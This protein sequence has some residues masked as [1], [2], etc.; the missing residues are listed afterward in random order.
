MF[1]MKRKGKKNPQNSC[2]SRRDQTARVSSNFQRCDLAAFLRASK[3]L[4]SDVGKH[5]LR[6]SEPLDNQRSFLTRASPQ[7]CPHSA[8]II[9]DY[10]TASNFWCHFIVLCFCFFSASFE[11]CATASSR[12]SPSYRLKSSRKCVKMRKLILC[13]P[14]SHFQPNQSR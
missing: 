6:L 4:C 7:V 13:L 9:T 1:Y 11:Y 3:I 14:I 10:I 8:V 2:C 5:R 12:H